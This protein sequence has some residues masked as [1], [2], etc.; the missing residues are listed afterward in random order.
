[1][2][3]KDETRRNYEIARI[4]RKA[5]LSRMKGS[6]GRKKKVESSGVWKKV[7]AIVLAVIVV[8][9]LIMWLLA[10]TGLLPKSS[11]A[12]TI[13]GRSWTAA[14]VNIAFG[15]YTA[16]RQYGF[17]FSPEF[18]AILDEPSHYLGENGSIRGDI[19]AEFMP[20][21]K[22]MSGLL[23]EMDAKNF[24]LTEEQEHTIDATSESLRN[25]FETMAEQSGQPV[26]L[27]IKTYYG[28]GVNV[29]MVE[30]DMRDSLRMNYYLEQVREEADVSDAALEKYY[31]EH[32]DDIDMYSYDAY[33]YKLDQGDDDAMSDDD[34]AKAYEALKER[35]E[36]VKSD[37]K[38]MDFGEALLEN[39]ADEEA[40]DA[41]RE[42]GAEAYEHRKDFA[43]EIDHKVFDFLKDADRQK[44]DA[45]VI[46]GDNQ[47]TVVQ[48]VERRRDDFKPYT[49]RHIL[50]ANDKSDGDGEDVE[51]MSDE[52]LKA[53]AERVLK[54]FN[55]GDRTE[56]SF[57]KLVVANSRDPGSL[58]TGGMYEDVHVGTMVR[59]FERW[60]QEDGRKAGD[61][62]IVKSSHGYHIMYFVKYG[63]PSLN[64][65]MTETL[66]N[67]YSQARTEEIIENA[68]ATFRPFGMKFVGRD[69]FF[70]GLFGKPVQVPTQEEL[71]AH[72]N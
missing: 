57:V 20:S 18:Q 30:R 48:F 41:L 13:D 58:Q 61:T 38:V 40:R 12:V 54:E 14:E 35:A 23:N 6:G 11:K 53:E 1:M 62:G 29:S 4:E 24:Q 27:I 7:T 9:A 46:E 17:A 39:A 36:R 66:K 70:G 44:G 45:A 47:V 49:V 72:T 50:I 19:V 64:D 51:Q 59:E 65:R 31:E 21:L 25:Q 52:E 69:S 43:H 33:T 42:A 8:L 2:A 56:E 3:K 63:E 71:T 34:K 32:K 68:Q 28:P 10:G 60:A 16:A 5:R 55:D 26:G 15:N 22:L 67:E 37:L